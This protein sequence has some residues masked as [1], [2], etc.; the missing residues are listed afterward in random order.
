[1]VKGEPSLDQL[2]LFKTGRLFRKMAKEALVEPY[3]FKSVFERQAAGF[4]G[5]SQ[6][7]CCD[8]LTYLFGLIN[9][10]ACQSAADARVIRETFQGYFLS[11]LECPVCTYRLT[12]DE[13][14]TFLPLPIC[15]KKASP[16]LPVVL[17]DGLLVTR[18]VLKDSGVRDWQE[19]AKVLAI[20]HETSWFCQ[21]R[22]RSDLQVL[23]QEEDCCAVLSKLQ[24]NKDELI[25]QLN[26]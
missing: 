6:H 1:M 22:E 25:I 18:R 12:S 3:G 19:L 2:L 15:P 9:E 20:D 16:E 10:L 4:K 14:F 17:L 21:G 13:M 11:T 5:Y 23:S 24:E 26:S 8:F 7:D